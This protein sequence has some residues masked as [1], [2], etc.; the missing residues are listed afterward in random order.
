MTAIGGVG[1]PSLNDELAPGNEG[2][3]QRKLA[4]LKA[5][6]E[7]RPKEELSTERE[8]V[9][10]RSRLEKIHTLAS[11]LLAEL[12]R[13]EAAL[14]ELATEV[15]AVFSLADTGR[16]I[17]VLTDVIN[18]LRQEIAAREESLSEKEE[19]CEEKKRQQERLIV[20]HDQALATL[21]KIKSASGEKYLKNP[22]L[23]QRAEGAGRWGASKA[24]S[25]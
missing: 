12:Q 13:D 19:Y 1:R 15:I 22:G 4:Y 21:Q 18:K 8:E 11:E 14:N 2:R 9:E 6:R 23:A 17:E 25:Y 5:R 24:S 10:R 3:L 20:L 7:G 16:Q